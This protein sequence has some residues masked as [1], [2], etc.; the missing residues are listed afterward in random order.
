MKTVDRNML[1]DVWISTQNG[2]K[3]PN[4][5]IRK[6]SGVSERLSRNSGC[7]KHFRSK[8]ERSKENFERYIKKNEKG[9]KELATQLA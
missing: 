8:V 5:S 9:H 1:T 3:M 7:E 2:D 4:R 6:I